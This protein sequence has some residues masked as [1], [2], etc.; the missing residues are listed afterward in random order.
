MA[1]PD[2]TTSYRSSDR[3]TTR[4][5]GLRLRNRPMHDDLDV[6]FNEIARIVRQLEDLAQEIQAEARDENPFA[7]DVQMMKI[8]VEASLKNNLRRLNRSTVL[9]SLF[10]CFLLYLWPN[11]S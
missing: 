4:Q 2:V 5:M 3:L 10:C 11:L 8:K 7:Y 1:P 6:P 9:F